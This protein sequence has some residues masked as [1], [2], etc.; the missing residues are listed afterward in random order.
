MGDVK[1][2]KV[3][4]G[5]SKRYDE[6][7]MQGY[8][9]ANVD[10]LVESIHKKCT[11]LDVGCGTGM[12]SLKLAKRGHDVRGFDFSENM[13][14]KAEENAKLQNAHVEFKV[15]DAEK[16][17]PFDVEFDYAFCMGSWEFFQ[18][19]K[20]VLSNVNSVLKKGGVFLIVTPD[21]IFA[22]FVILAEK[23]KIK[24]L[25]PSYAYFN[26]F[27]FRIKQ[28]AKE[29]DFILEKKGHHNWFFDRVFILRK[30]K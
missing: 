19:P 7:R 14:K 1:L 28:W 29:T 16:E 17:I 21:P 20:A 10:L 2:R 23:L 25:A 3:Y 24:K 12:Y 22:P 5:L 27:G 8:F 4:D 11:V 26:S 18:E 9:D 15:G 6:D 30:V 13:I